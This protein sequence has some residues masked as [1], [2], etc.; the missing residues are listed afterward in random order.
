MPSQ[1]VE[2]LQSMSIFGAIRDDIVEFIIERAP[3]LIV[4]AG[5][6]FFREGDIADSMFV[7]EAGE[8]AVVKGDDG[9]LLRHVVAGQCFG[10]MSLI[11]L[12]P[13]SASVRAITDCTA[14]RITSGCLYDVYGKDVEQFAIIEMNMAREVS[15]RMREL[16][17]AFDAIGGAAAAPGVTAPRRPTADCVAGRRLLRIRSRVG[18]PLR[19]FAS[20]RADVARRRRVAPERWCPRRRSRARRLRP[21]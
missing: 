18:A 10:E 13:R 2:L 19:L 8:A 4:S 6:Y 16:D 9:H 21:Q 5:D 20:C 12:A 1:R 11:D 17:A 15:R 14:L 3:P 7:L